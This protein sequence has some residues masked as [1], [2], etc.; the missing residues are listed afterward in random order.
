MI[1]AMI[2]DL[3]GTLLDSV[4]TIYEVWMRFCDRLNL[5][6]LDLTSFKQYYDTDWIDFGRTILQKDISIGTKE[7]QLWMDI[8]NQLRDKVALHPGIKDFLR[9]LK[10]ENY[11]VALVTGGNR[12]RVRKELA[13]FGI[14]DYFDAILT[15]EDVLVPKPSP[16][17]LLVTAKRL[18]VSPHECVYI[19][20][21]M[22]DVVAARN[23]G[24]F[25]VA[26]DWGFHGKNQLR[27]A[28]ALHIAQSVY[29]LNYL[30]KNIGE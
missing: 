2:F 26:V 29:D 15:H 8:Y 16:V 1:K 4:E 9:R 22:G 5:K 6:R 10:E 12:D 23:A 18:G 28:G 27:S 21:M 7:H 11:K 30:L 19:G 14:L 24:M 20:D 25:A 3:D 13:R 17:G